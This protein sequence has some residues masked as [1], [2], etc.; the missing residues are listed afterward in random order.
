MSKK[1]YE[2]K[3]NRNYKGLLKLFSLL[4][5]LVGISGLLYVFFPLVSWQIY[6]APVF[7]SN[8]VASPI[9]KYTIVNRSNIKNLVEEAVKF[10]KID[11]GNARNW[12]SPNNL[13]QN[14]SAI[15]SY[16]LSIKKLGIKDAFVSTKDYIIDNHLVNYGGTA[17][18][19]DKGTAVI[20]GHST[21][22]QLFNPKNYRAI[23]ATLYTLQ[24]GDEI[25][26]KV[27]DVNYKYKIF[28]I[29]VVNPDDPSIFTQNFDDSYITLVTCTPPGTTWKRLLIKARLEKI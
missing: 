8:D 25:D 6:F 27:S 17:I 5:F 12:F 13:P 21:L 3:K 23:F 11:Y 1:Y 2:K 9:P 4:I 24:I 26:I 18:P 22:P 20:V 7:A 29:T 19:P 28:N 14:S 15:E 16:S 10:K